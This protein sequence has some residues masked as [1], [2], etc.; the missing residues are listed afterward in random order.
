MLN[1]SSRL[2]SAGDTVAMMHVLVRP[3]SES[4]SS[5]VSLLS[6]ERSSEE[7]QHIKKEKRIRPLKLP[8]IFALILCNKIT[9]SGGN[10]T[11][12][13]K[14]VRYLSI[15]VTPFRVETRQLTGHLP[16]WDVRGSIHKC[17]NDTT[18]GQETLVNI[19]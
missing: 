2:M 11:P 1:V 14:H 18:K 13:G 6:L 10:I 19:S 16:I 3:P 12:E 15:M 5:L 17:R 9:L 4:C 7:E 8:L